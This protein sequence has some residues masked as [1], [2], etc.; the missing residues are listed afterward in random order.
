[1]IQNVGIVNTMAHVIVAIVGI[2]SSVD[3]IRVTIMTDNRGCD[4][5]DREILVPRNFLEL[6]RLLLFFLRLLFL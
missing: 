2:V 6:L 3:N 4:M 5:A 1:M